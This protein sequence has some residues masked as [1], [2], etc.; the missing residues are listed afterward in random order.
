MNYEL[1]LILYESGNVKTRKTIVKD[2]TRIY[3]ELIIG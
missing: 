1:F 2:D 3:E